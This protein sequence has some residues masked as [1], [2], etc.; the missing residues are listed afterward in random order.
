MMHKVSGSS[1]VSTTVLEELTFRLVRNQIFFLVCWLQDK[2]SKGTYH[3]DSFRVL[4][5]F[6]VDNTDIYSYLHG[7][8]HTVCSGDID[9]L[10]QNFV[11]V[12]RNLCSPRTWWHR[13]AHLMI[14]RRR[15]YMVL[16][17]FELKWEREIELKILV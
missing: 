6:A 2:L 17:L 13:S 11:N 3:H 16:F 4:G 12:E 14:C 8:P 1:A 5:T 7:R 15:L 10:Q 9:N